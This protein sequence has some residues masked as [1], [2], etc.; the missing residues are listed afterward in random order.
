MSARITIADVAGSLHRI[1]HHIT[2]EAEAGKPLSEHLLREAQQSLST[3]DR[4]TQLRTIAYPVA[5]KPREV[6]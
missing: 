6:A 5:S 1:L 4:I 2:L 3:A